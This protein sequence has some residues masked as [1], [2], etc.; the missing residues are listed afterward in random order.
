MLREQGY[1]LEREKAYSYSYF[2]TSAVFL[3]G[4]KLFGLS[5]LFYEIE[6]IIM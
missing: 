6:V 1:I 3:I 4:L 5:F 2:P